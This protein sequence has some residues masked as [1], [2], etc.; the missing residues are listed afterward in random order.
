[1][2]DEIIS[3]PHF[4]ITAFPATCGDSFWISYG[5]CDCKSHLLIDGGTAGTFEHI[6][7]HIQSIGDDVEVE[8]LVVTHYDRDHIEGIIKLLS[9][10]T[11]PVKIKEI[12]FNDY[13]RLDKTLEDDESFGALMGE[14]LSRLINLHKIPW[15]KS[16]NDNAVVIPNGE[17]ENLPTYILAGGI[18]VTLL[19][20]YQK[21]L[22]KLKPVWETEIKEADKVPGYGA[23]LKQKDGDEAFGSQGPKFAELAKEDFNA[24]SS[25][26]NGSSIAILLDYKGK[27]ILLSGNAFSEN[28]LKSLIFLKRRE[29]SLLKVS[30]HGGARNTDPLLIEQIDCK[31]FL[32]STNSNKKPKDVTLAYILKST[33]N[34]VFYFNYI[35]QQI[36]DWENEVAKFEHKYS[37]IYPDGKPLEIDILKLK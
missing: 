20:P 24:D 2:T 12:W 14:E 16:F 10:K 19:S 32:F 22:T 18:S 26:G 13:T 36:R 3:N 35:E 15:N 4:T 9:L 17:L 6:I 34:P 28:I 23:K 21:Q 7:R 25:P 27:S 11:P 29:I 5:D 8:L 30:H 1:M 31:H 33:D 37:T